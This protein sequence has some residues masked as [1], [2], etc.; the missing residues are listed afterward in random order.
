[1]PS[2]SVHRVTAPLASALLHIELEDVI[3]F[4]VNLSSSYVE[5]NYLPSKQCREAA[6]GV[7]KENVFGLHVEINSTESAF[8][9][10][11]ALL[12]KRKTFFKNYTAML[13]CF[14][15]LPLSS[16]SPTSFFFLMICS[17]FAIY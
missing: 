14:S 3:V 2:P 9:F 17:L 5:T 1:M 10:S 15:T 11:A 16:G 13:I 7:H 8:L 6:S 12:L 4:W